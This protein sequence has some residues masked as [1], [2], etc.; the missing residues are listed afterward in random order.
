MDWSGVLFIVYVTVLV[1]G[2]IFSF[3]LRAS[4]MRRVIRA[5]TIVLTLPAG[6]VILCTAVLFIFMRASEPPTLGELQKHFA[7]RKTA[8]ETLV[9][10]S[11]EDAHYSRIAPTFVDRDQ[12]SDGPGRYMD[13]DPKAGLAKSRWDEYRAIYK[14]NDIK[15][16]VQRDEGEDFFIM[17]DSVGLLNRGHS[18]GYLFCVQQKDEAKKYRFQ[19][20]RQ[21]QN[22]GSHQFDPNTREEGY[23]FR[24]LDGSWFA[25]DE[26]PS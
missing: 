17:A 10:M 15:L 11:K 24:R 25:Y 16:G 4:G 6:L 18:T 23:S 8:L 1:A 22:E 12:G 5:I 26:G 7:T 14:L 2:T 21:D 9:R 3:A 20:C 13:G 19:P